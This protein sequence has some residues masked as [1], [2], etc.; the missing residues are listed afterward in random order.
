MGR[1]TGGESRV[2]FLA[3]GHR[4]QHMRGP[5]G[6]KEPVLC[7]YFIPVDVDVLYATHGGRELA[8][9]VRE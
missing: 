6:T 2:G 5:R 3:Y 1:N 7:W 8:P 9:G 4:W